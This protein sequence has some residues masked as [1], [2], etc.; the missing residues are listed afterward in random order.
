[1][2]FQEVK[3]CFESITRGSFGEEGDKFMFREVDDP[4]RI[5]KVGEEVNDVHLIRGGVASELLSPEG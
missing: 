5:V 1:M 4:L 2:E 3:H